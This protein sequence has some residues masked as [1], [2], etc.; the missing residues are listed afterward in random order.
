MVLDHENIARVHLRME[1]R[2]GRPR[3]WRRENTATGA[4]GHQ[5][6]ASCRDIVYQAQRVTLG[7]CRQRGPAFR[8]RGRREWNRKQPM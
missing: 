3:G 7:G 4:K 8:A 6:P 1:A 2:S 5:G